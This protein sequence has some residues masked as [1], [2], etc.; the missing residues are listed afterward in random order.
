LVVLVLHYFWHS[1]G[2]KGSDHS[3]WFPDV[4]VAGIVTF[5]FESR[6]RECDLEVD[7]ETIRMR[8]GALELG[9][10]RVP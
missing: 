4:V 7:D 5:L 1:N 2:R 10:R 8:G 3:E 9:N 6:R